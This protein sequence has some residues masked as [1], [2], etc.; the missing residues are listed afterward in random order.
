MHICTHAHSYCFYKM[1]TTACDTGFHVQ[2]QPFTERSCREINDDS[3]VFWKRLGVIKTKRGR[4]RGTWHN[5]VV[6]VLEAELPMCLPAET[7][8]CPP[9]VSMWAAICFNLCTRC[10]AF[11]SPLVYYNM[12]PNTIWICLSRTTA[13]LLHYWGICVYFFSQDFSTITYLSPLW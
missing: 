12:W 13:D 9:F 7:L 10:V 5:S 2:R 8:Q 11:R 3:G 1:T 6:L 4:G